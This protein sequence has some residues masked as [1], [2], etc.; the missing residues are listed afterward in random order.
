MLIIN[1]KVSRSRIAWAKPH[2]NLGVQF[3]SGIGYTIIYCIRNSNINCVPKSVWGFSQAI[4]LQYGSIYLSRHRG[5]SFSLI[6]C[7][8]L[9]ILR[10]KWLGIIG[11]VLFFL[12]RFSTDNTLF[13][14]FNSDLQII[15]KPNPKI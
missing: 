7:I 13:N 5:E 2:T 9:T 1:I 4:R 14:L 6:L 8:Y 3:I 11:Q 12:L 15:G 10:S